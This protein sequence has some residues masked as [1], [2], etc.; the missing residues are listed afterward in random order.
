MGVVVGAWGEAAGDLGEG[1]LS[2]GCSEDPY[3]QNLNT[4]NVS[5]H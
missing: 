3:K 1:D 4:L 2:I 5:R